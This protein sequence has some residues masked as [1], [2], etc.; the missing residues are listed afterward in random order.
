MKKIAAVFLTLALLLS[1]GCCAASTPQKYSGTFFDA[2]DTVITISGYADTE[3]EFNRAYEGAKELFLHYHQVFDAYNEYDGVDNLCKVNRLAVQGPTPAATELLDFLSWLK[4]KQPL[5]GGRVNVSMGSVLFIWHDYRS[6]GVAVPDRNL[7]EDAANHTDFDDVVIDIDNGTIL[8]TDD[9]LCLDLGAVA[10][11]Y[12]A[13]IAGEWLHNHGM[14]SYIINAGGNVVAGDPPLDGRTAWG[15]GVQKPRDGDGYQAI[16]YASNVSL[17]TS[18]DYQ[19]YYTVDGVNY[20][21]LIDPDTLFPGQYMQSVTIVCE[22]SGL[23][24]LL[25]TAVFLSPYEEGKALVASFDGVEAYWVLADGSA[26]MTPG[27]MDYMR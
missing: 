1:C 26:R 6:E 15:I 7:L 25:S 21:H 12:T 14:P 27:M 11:G 9:R 20:H 19:R 3:A 5:T 13:Q 22:D 2:F 23:A 24:D 16:L 18:G 8:Y 4:E 10:K 17:V